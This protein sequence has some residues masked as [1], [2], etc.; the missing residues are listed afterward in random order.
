MTKQKRNSLATAPLNSAL[1]KNLAAYIAAAGAAG[2]ALAAG[3]CRPESLH[4]LLDS[5][6]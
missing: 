4:K 2:V 5:K 6:F 3:R 1:N